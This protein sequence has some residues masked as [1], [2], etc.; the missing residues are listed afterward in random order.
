MTDTFDI[1]EKCYKNKEQLMTA[2]E[3][4][5]K[6]LDGLVIYAT[7]IAPFP[8]RETGHLVTGAKAYYISKLNDLEDQ[9]LSNDED[10]RNFNEVIIDDE[11]MFPNNRNQKL[12][13]DYDVKKG[14]EL[15]EKA[16]TENAIDQ[17][18]TQIIS[19]FR[20]CYE[21]E[22]D[23]EDILVFNSSTE[24]KYSYHLVIDNFY[25]KGHLQSREFMLKV[26]KS[27]KSDLREGIDKC[28]YS[29]FQCFR[30]MHCKKYGKLNFKR[31][32][33]TAKHKDIFLRS[34]VSNVKNCHKLQDL[35]FEKK[36]VSRE[37]T[38]E[39][40]DDMKTYDEDVLDMVMS[41]L[42]SDV[43]RK[44]WYLLMCAF[45]NMGA[46]IGMIRDWS[47]SS[48]KYDDEA[49]NEIEKLEY[50]TFPTHLPYVL[51]QLKENLSEDE[52]KKI[53]KVFYT[54]NEE[55]LPV[56]SLLG[57]KSP[58]KGKEEVKEIDLEKT[59]MV[60]AS[61]QTDDDI[62]TYCAKMFRKNVKITS[63]RSNSTT[64][65]GFMWNDKTKLW[66]PKERDM[67]QY[68]MLNNLKSKFE[69]TEN[70]IGKELKEAWLG[71]SARDKRDSK[72]F[73]I[74]RLYHKFMKMIK[75]AHGQ[76]SIFRLTYPKL[77]D[78]EFY[79]KI[80]P[81]DSIWLPLKNGKKYNMKTKE[82]VDRDRKDLFSQEIERN[83]VENIDNAT[84]Y[85]SEL[86][87]EG[88]KW[89]RANKIVGYLWTNMNNLKMIFI[90][91]GD[92]DTGKSTF[93]RLL[94]KLMGLF[95]KPLDD[96]AIMEGRQQSVHNDE[97]AY[98]LKR[99]FVAVCNETKADQKIN[100]KVAKQICGNDM[101]ALRTCGGNTECIYPRTK[102]IIA[103]NIHPTISG[104][105]TFHEKLM[106]LVF[107]HS[108]KA[109]KENKEKV[110]AMEKD[111]EFLDQL[112]TLQM[113]GAYEYYQEPNIEKDNEGRE[114]FIEKNPIER[115]LEERCEY[116]EKYRYPTEQ[117]WRDFCDWNNLNRDESYDVSA[118]HF[119][120]ILQGKFKKEVATVQ[121]KRG[122]CYWGLRMKTAS[123]NDDED[124]KSNLPIF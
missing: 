64:P 12:K 116:D 47:K 5:G 92:R 37:Y 10:N 19:T 16:K 115:W 66:E 91:I 79:E 55:E 87:G 74:P 46:S 22:I 18:K 53:V 68:F 43:D 84:A 24:D 67:I 124:E 62:S 59:K 90:F 30:L 123:R 86:F 13:F 77:Y 28:P 81:M 45:K 78:E 42:S 71:A 14:H 56:P 111:E 57:K 27:W 106:H 21:V 60:L 100:E 33:G 26:K 118:V 73:D 117:A 35:P 20:D 31:Y 32:V 82:L 88:A 76:Q 89:K 75:S 7:D 36:R 49:E 70:V 58:K 65:F 11:E 3:K 93:L 34:L 44:E 48:G 98:A 112:F 95:F 104:D 120:K 40:V 103:G 25:V 101:I 109:T 50:E 114:K 39:T 122:A 8:H 2:L 85:M 102:I 80:D 72:E 38:Y 61:L 54:P 15:F 97:L 23:D 69:N 105:D 96:K 4:H 94:N 63:L 121:R 113:L 51:F 99:S 110:A 9:I 29:V 41:N 108:F 119:K 1:T 52:Y 6:S 83:I 107:P 17:L